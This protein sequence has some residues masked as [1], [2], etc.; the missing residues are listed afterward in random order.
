[1]QIDGA[2]ERFLIQLDADGR[3][4]H[5]IRQ[6]RRHVRLFA[7]WCADVGHT[8]A[9]GAISHEDIA[10]FLA[11][12]QARTRPDGR[13]KKATSVNVLRGTTA[14]AG[15]SSTPGPGEISHSSG[16]PLSLQ[17]SFT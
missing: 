16:I 15:A 8:G 11:S 14:A 3:S 13:A 9:I 17:S 4:Q 6:Y 5:T 2:L 10:R 7:A 12:P 1:M